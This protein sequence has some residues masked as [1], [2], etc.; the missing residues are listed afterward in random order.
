MQTNVAS[1]LVPNENFWF[2]EADGHEADNTRS[3]FGGAKS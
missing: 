3:R 2:K 1:G